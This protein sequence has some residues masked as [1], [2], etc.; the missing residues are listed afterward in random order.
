[1]C[2]TPPNRESE[3]SAVRPVAAC[4][5]PDSRLATPGVGRFA[6]VAL[7]LCFAWIPSAGAQQAPTAKVSPKSQDAAIALAPFEVKTTADTG[8]NVTDSNS[9]LKMAVDTKDLPFSLSVLS[10]DLL[11]DFAAFNETEGLRLNAGINPVE[12]FIAKSQNRP[13]IRGTSSVRVYADGLFLNSLVTPNIAIDRVEVLKGTSGNLFGIGEPGGTLNYVYKPALAKAKVSLNAGLGSWAERFAQLDLGGP[14]AADG[15]LTARFGIG[16]QTGEA[17]NVYTK[18]ETKE[19]YARLRY[20]FTPDTTLQLT[21]AQSDRHTDSPSRLSY[22]GLAGR[23]HPVNEASQ[24]ARYQSF[25]ADLI[26]SG[27]LNRRSNTQTPDS[28]ADVVTNTFGAEINHKFSARWWLRAAA[29]RTHMDRDS[30]LTPIWFDTPVTAAGTTLSPHPVTGQPVAT[31][32]ARGDILASADG[33]TLMFDNLASDS[34]QINLLG[35]FD[36]NRGSWRTVLGADYNQEVFYFDRWR[37]NWIFG[38][39]AAENAVLLGPTLRVQSIVANVLQPAAGWNLKQATPPRSTFTVPAGNST[40]TVQGPGYYWINHLKLFSDRL[41]FTGSVRRDE[42][43]ANNKQFRQISRTGLT[44]AK[45]DRPQTTHSLGAVLYITKYLSA[46]VN[47]GTTFRPQAALVTDRAQ[48]V[49]L[50]QPLSGNGGDI[51]FRLDLP[52]QHLQLSAGAFRVAQTNFIVTVTERQPDGTNLTWQEQSGENQVDGYELEAS[53]NLTS[54][55]S[56]NLSFVHLD[57]FVKRN[58]QLPL[59]VGQELAGTPAN[60]VVLLGRYTFNDRLSIGGAATVVRDDQ[61]FLTAPN[62]NPLSRSYTSGYHQAD[63]FATYSFRWRDQHRVRLQLNLYNLT[64]ELYSAEFGTS[65][66]FGLRFST[67][68]SF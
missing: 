67:N 48:N 51:G 9:A 66:P 18:F 56:V 42:A 23:H 24:A 2:L 34:A 29:V 55:L 7:A 53:A 28:F 54:A 37:S 15:K 45:A 62:N 30:L 61:Y 17:F 50:A 35:H 36:F 21:L 20:A 25:G 14:L 58:R 44:T 11:R 1:M 13:Y 16:Y 10:A 65:K 52:R 4:T 8:Y 49:S 26:T 68:W 41:V 19:F 27:L 64:N 43:E 22:D 59:Q 60:K 46:Y 57:S 39:T 12:N 3:F 31:P 6:G 38:P 40:N 33:G 32:T 5:K 47:D 63:L